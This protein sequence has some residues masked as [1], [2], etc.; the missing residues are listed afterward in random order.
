[1]KLINIFDPRNCY[2]LE[3]FVISRFG[4]SAEGIL[5]AKECELAE[6]MNTQ[7]L[8]HLIVEGLLK[9]KEYMRDLKTYATSFEKDFDVVNIYITPTRKTLVAEKINLVEDLDQR[10]MDYRRLV[11]KFVS[12]FDKEIS[13]VEYDS[14]GVII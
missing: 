9:N 8:N 7:P 2:K 5:Q 12:K 3:N 4:M 13:S 14:Q 10:F 1:M 11:G 6:Y